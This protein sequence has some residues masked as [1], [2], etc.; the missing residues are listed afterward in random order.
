MRSFENKVSKIYRLKYLLFTIVVAGMMN[1]SC[2]SSEADGKSGIIK[3]N[4]K[5]IN[6]EQGLWQDQEE[7]PVEFE[8][9]ETIDLSQI[10]EPIISGIA[11][12]SFDDEDNMYFFD[13]RQ[14]KMISIDQ[15]GNLRWAKGQEG[16]GPGDFESPF[17][18]AIHGD[19]IYV[20]NIQGSRLDEFDL[21][22]NFI[23]SY[24]LPKE[25]N[26]AS[27][28]GIRENGEVLMSGANF[29][30]IGADI[31]ILELGDSLKLKTNFSIIETE[32]EQYQN[33]TSRGT[34]SMY[35]DFFVYA[36][37]TS[38]GH[39]YYDYDSTM[40]KEVIRKFDGVLGPGMYRT[41]NSVSI[42][43]LGNVGAPI[44]LDGGYYLVNVR[45]PT[46]IN[47][48]NAY[49]KRASTGETESPIYE[50]FMDLYNTEGEL[51]YVYDNSEEVEALGNLSARD[52][53]GFYYSTFSNDLLIK[54]YRVAVKYQSVGEGT[55]Q[56]PV[57]MD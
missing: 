4:G 38:N 43:S 22:G 35:E 39:R 31:S 46:N 14:M 7:L 6:P 21:D 26:F 49:A 53:Q 47:D 57:T 23:R 50:E 36:F 11:Y 28:I 48:P 51:L 8:L 52:S 55:E 41:D 27:I 12:L 13:R 15:E 16:K 10:E 56:P 3:E 34:I 42:Y 54:K 33:A 37:S 18:M 32:D 1:I 44:Y 5:V 20:A 29:G 17:G 9:V 25:I 24:D 30:T 40:T 19:R 2:T 45:Y